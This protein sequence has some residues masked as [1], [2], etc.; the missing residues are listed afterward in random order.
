[1][2]KNSNN[3]FGLIS[4]LVHWI[5]ALML[6]TLFAVGFWMVDLSYYSEWYRVAPYYHKAF[7]LLLF[8]LTLFRITW[9]F[10]TPQ[11]DTIAKSSTERTFAR[12]G[13]IALYIAML[14]I[15][16]SGY[17]ISTADGRGIELFSIVTIPS[18]GELIPNQEDV[19][20]VIHEYAAYTIMVL[21]V[22]H[23]TA[24]L[25]HHF[26]DKDE[27]LTRMTKTPRS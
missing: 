16:M 1:M 25:K 18:M 7:G 12:L 9:K 5:S 21:I 15:M 4:K 11:P 10:A 19:A 3:Q 26:I 23:I 24:A 17:L 27:T 8:A 22:G 2:L 13:H 14:V 20:G 6:L